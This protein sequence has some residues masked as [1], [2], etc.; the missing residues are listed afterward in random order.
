MAKEDDSH[1]RSASAWSTMLYS[2]SI[3]IIVKSR[4]V[5]G[6]LPPKTTPRLLKQAARPLAWT[7]GAPTIP[8]LRFH[9]LRD[10][11]AAS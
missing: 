5:Y 8:D 1:Q 3:I 7:A 6:K 4:T 9:L 11:P 10:L 2:L